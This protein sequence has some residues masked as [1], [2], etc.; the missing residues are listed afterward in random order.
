[1]LYDHVSGLELEIEAYDLEQRERD[2]SSGFTRAVTIVSLHG[3]GE[4]GR[5]ED[6]TY[7]NDA[8]DALH[9]SAGDCSVMGEYTLDEFSDQVSEIDLFHGT[10]PNQAIFRNSGRQK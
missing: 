9:G 10:E 2:T 6:V 8:H 1:M 4:I 5:G 7:D 3:D